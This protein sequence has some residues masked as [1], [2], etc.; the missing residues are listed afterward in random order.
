M[1]WRSG[2]F[3]LK[4]VAKK[5]K[6]TLRVDIDQ[7]CD[8]K[9]DTMR[10]SYAIDKMWGVKLPHPLLE[11]NGVVLSGIIFLNTELNKPHFLRDLMIFMHCSL[12]IKQKIYSIGIFRAPVATQFIVKVLRKIEK[13][14]IFESL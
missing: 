8:D 7:F 13:S 5:S 1:S 6:N 9:R 3:Q 4:T 14:P 12:Q 11:K 2:S 10:I